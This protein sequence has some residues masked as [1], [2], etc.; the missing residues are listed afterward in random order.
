MTLNG[1]TSKIKKSGYLSTNAGGQNPK[2]QID[3]DKKIGTQVFQT[4]K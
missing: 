3:C 1:L 2:N 4:E